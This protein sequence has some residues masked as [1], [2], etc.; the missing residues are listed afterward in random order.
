[1]SLYYH[2]I[3]C[4]PYV[5]A[6][7]PQD[8]YIDRVYSLTLPDLLEEVSEFGLDMKHCLI[9]INEI[10]NATLYAVSI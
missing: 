3:K 5:V 4:K 10:R 1:M 6:E 2:V 9:L 8:P 7:Q